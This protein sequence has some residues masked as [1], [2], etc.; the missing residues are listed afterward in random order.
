MAFETMGLNAKTPAQPE[1]PLKS[2]RDQM[3][4]FDYMDHGDTDFLTWYSR[5]KPLF[6]DL[7]DSQKVSLILSRLSDRIYQRLL[8]HFS[9]KEP[10]DAKFD[11][12]KNFLATTYCAAQSTYDRRYG[13]FHQK[14]DSSP[15]VEYVDKMNAL[16]DACGLESCSKEE[17][18][19][20]LIL[21]TMDPELHRALVQKAEDKRLS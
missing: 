14:Y 4:I 16:F 18:R 21:N 3:S 7:E 1:D 10:S 9:P 17:L 2:L 12:I 20:A 8:Q 6:N 13:F 11:E 15:L 19:V 5:V